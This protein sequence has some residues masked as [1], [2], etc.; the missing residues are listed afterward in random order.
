MM[1]EDVINLALVKLWKQ[2]RFTSYFY[3]LV[4]CKQTESIPT[5]ALSVSMRMVLYYNKKFIQT[6]S[7]DECI[8]LL[9]HEM[10]HVILEHDHRAVNKDAVLQN[11][12]QDMVINTFLHKHSKD[13]FSYKGQYQ[14]DVPELV[15]PK[16]LPCIPQDYF[17]QTQNSDPHWEDVYHWL[18]KMDNELTVLQNEHNGKKQKALMHD[19]S[20]AIVTDEGNNADSEFN[21]RNY[22]MHSQADD[23]KIMLRDENAYLPTG[24]HFF[25]DDN[26]MCKTIKNKL[27]A[28]AKKDEWCTTER[29][30]LEIA[31]LLENVAAS[32]RY[33]G[34]YVKSI[35]DYM[36]HS[37]EWYYTH[38][39]FN[40]RYASSGIYSAGR[41]YKQS[42]IITV[43][44]DISASMTAQKEELQLAFG[45]IDDLTEK[46]KVHLV[47]VDEE[48]FIP[49]KQ[50]D[51]FIRSER[52]AKRYE[53]TKG[54]WKYIKSGYGGAT[55][56]SSFFN[57]YVQGHKEMVIV[58]TDG[59]I[60]DI[61]AL[62]PYART[63]WLVS[64]SGNEGFVAPFGRSIT[65]S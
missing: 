36:S 55:F 1:H 39:K 58:I 38:S 30:Y 33:Y 28:H 29:S 5:L 62:Q 43:A 13:Y 19:D 59:Y 35:I 56:F 54:D 64:K 25:S 20:C 42:E 61:N 6:I 51:H 26:T 23:E 3:H 31:A 16:G 47:C 21:Y 60:Y 53:Y 49:V 32:D 7:Q 65:M 2:S 4:E 41:A 44:V 17:I 57:D 63:L 50:D 27:I 37:S 14:W 12:A 10:L 15:I 22:L 48:Y 40:R 8:G 34:R 46:Y 18:V 24:I 52:T 45:I 9:V 11:I